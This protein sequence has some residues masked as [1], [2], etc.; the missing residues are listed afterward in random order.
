MSRR[1]R[2]EDEVIEVV[3]DEPE[4]E[5]EP[6]PAAI[7]IECDEAWQESCP[8]CKHELGWFPAGAPLI[9]ETK[10]RRCRACR[11][12]RITKRLR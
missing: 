10:L 1:K 3:P 11:K 2:E 7:E 8:H 9:G 12:S 4:V 5:P 6:R